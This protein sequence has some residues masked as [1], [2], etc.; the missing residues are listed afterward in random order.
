MFQDKYYE[1]VQGAMKGYSI[2]PVVA[3][4]FMEEFEAKALST[5]PPPRIWLRY[6]DDNFVVHKAEY[7]QQFL[8]LLNSIDPHIQF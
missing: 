2:S 6:V 5:S 4:L 8:T 3:N 7:I 1:Q